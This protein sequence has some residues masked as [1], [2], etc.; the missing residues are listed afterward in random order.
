[1]DQGNHSNLYLSIG[2]A[3]SSILSGLIGYVTAYNLAW[4]VSFSAGIVAIWAGIMTIK[5]HRIT[6]AEKKMHIEQMKKH[7]NF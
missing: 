7:N 4:L 6:I 2:G 5:V 3:I 1:M